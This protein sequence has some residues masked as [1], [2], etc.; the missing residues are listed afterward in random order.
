MVVEQNKRKAHLY[1]HTYGISILRALGTPQTPILSS[2]FCPLG[3]K[4][5]QGG[6]FLLWRFFIVQSKL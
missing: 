5:K 4:Q 1:G 6:V 2:D 3:Q